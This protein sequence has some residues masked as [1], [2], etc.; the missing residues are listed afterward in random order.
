MVLPEFSTNSSCALGNSARRFGHR[1][2]SQR[3][4]F[5]NQVY[6][7]FQRAKWKNSTQDTSEN[8][9]MDHIVRKVTGVQREYYHIRSRGCKAGSWRVSLRNRWPSRLELDW[10]FCEGGGMT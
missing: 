2:H 10:A 7:P 3:Y 9:V 4:A 8:R 6:L 1:T 5:I